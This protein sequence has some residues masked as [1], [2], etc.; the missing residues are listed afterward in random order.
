M[1]STDSEGGAVDLHALSDEELLDRSRRLVERQNRIAA[2]LARTVRAADNKQAFERDGMKSAQ[3]WL[4]GHCRLS[5]AAA[6]QVVRNGRALEHLPAV[7]AGHADGDLTADQVSLIGLLTA[8]R[9]VASLEAQDGDL[10]AIA[11]VL[12]RYATVRRHDELT[13]LV[14]EVL[15]RI[16]QDGPEPDPTEERFLSFAK[17]SDGSITGRFH[18]DAVGGEKL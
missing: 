18:L 12:A 4:R 8:P 11:D 15:A 10:A 2:E 9:C 17:H 13:K 6:S 1:C 7:G 16:D 5:R 3:S 14:H